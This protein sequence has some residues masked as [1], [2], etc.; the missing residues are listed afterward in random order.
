MSRTGKKM[1]NRFPAFKA[2]REASE[3]Y[4][5]KAMSAYALTALAKSKIFVLILG[6][7]KKKRFPALL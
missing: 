7:K 3:T 1:F 4:V 6:H 5:Y 2:F